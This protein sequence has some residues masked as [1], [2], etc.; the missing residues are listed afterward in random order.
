MGTEDGGIHLRTHL[1]V[2]ERND[3]LF[4]EIPWVLQAVVYLHAFVTGAA[5]TQPVLSLGWVG[6]RACTCRL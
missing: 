6:V 5:S 4:L 2:S 3:R 1:S